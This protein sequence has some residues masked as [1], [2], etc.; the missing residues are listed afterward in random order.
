MQHKDQGATQIFQKLDVHELC[1]ACFHSSIGLSDCI[2][3]HSLQF[4]TNYEFFDD[5]RIENLGNLYTHQTVLPL[6]RFF[7][8]LDGGIG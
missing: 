2:F 6:T 7:E 1:A 4:K 3:Y 5:R 8:M